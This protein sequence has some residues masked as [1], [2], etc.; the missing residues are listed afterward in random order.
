MLPRA[1]DAE[2]PG[3]APPPADRARAPLLLRDAAP[4]VG[5]PVQPPRAATPAV[6]APMRSLRRPV[7]PAVVGADDSGDEGSGTTRDAGKPARAAAL[8]RQLER[9]GDPGATLSGLSK[10]ADEGH[11]AVLARLGLAQVRAG[12]GDQGEATL[13]RVIDAGGA[14]DDEARARAQYGQAEAFHRVFATVQPGS[15]AEAA[16]E[17][18]TL[19]ELA[20]QAYLKAAR[21]GSPVFTAAALGRLATLATTAAARLKALQVTGVTAA[22]AQAIQQGLAQRAATLEAT[23]RDALAGCAELAWTRQV[24][25]A[26]VRACLSGTPPKDD[27]VTFERLTPRTP[28]GNLPALDGLRQTVSRNPEDLEALRALGEGLLDAGDAHAARLAFARAVQAGGGPVE[29][30]L[31]GIASW[32]AGDR[33]GALEAFARAAGGG[34]EGGRQNL[35]DG[36]RQAGLGGA[37]DE[38]MK[39]FPVGRPGGRTLGGG[40]G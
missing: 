1:V 24:F 25:A 2:E 15:D 12:Q 4:A 20:E 6:G 9:Q 34:L 26:P 16:Q 18:V 36:L 37:A 33:T 10:L 17:L 28:A 31:L 38:A 5:A 35:A 22:Q 21:E 19:A 27:P 32:R 13:Q 7:A 8:A 23:A 30:N 14:A 40:A 3:S 11:P 29:Q 39:R